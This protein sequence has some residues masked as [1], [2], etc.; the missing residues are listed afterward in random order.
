MKYMEF[1]E[2]IKGRAKA[3]QKTIVLP[4]TSDI[5][6]L[7]AATQILSEKIA[8]II[9]IG[10]KEDIIQKANGLDLSTAIF[11]D[12]Y[13]YEKSEELV[14][15]LYELRKAKGMTLV[16]AKELIYKNE[17]YFGIMLVKIGVADG[18]VAGAVNS[19]PDVL[20]PC[21]RILKTSPSSKLVSSFF[22]MCIPDCEYGHNGTFIYGDCGMNQSPSENDLAN[23]A[24]NSAKAFKHLTGVEPVVA[25][26]SNSTM[27]S[28]KNDEVLKVVNATKIAK[29]LEPL[30]SI[31]GEFQVD[32][33]IVKEIGAKKAPG[34]EVAGN[35]N[36]LIFPD[37]QSGNIG[38]KLTERLAKAKA[39]GPITA[40][41]A[42]SVND[43]S[44][45]CTS[46]DIVGVVAITAVQAQNPI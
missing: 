37:L 29:E 28:T 19:S 5:R 27:G 44:R 43:L 23:I 21:V 6:T 32:A 25:M 24:I 3:D 4:E 2:S 30:I 13:T 41:I 31:D 34:N 15:I 14:K 20:S 11:I 42:K 40:G 46:D 39:Y 26:L 18:M 17:L 36:V 1:I 16:E 10:N 33:A 8:K 22:V 7:I 12:P 35:A 9:L 45:G 38:Y